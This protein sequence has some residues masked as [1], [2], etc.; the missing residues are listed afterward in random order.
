MGNHTDSQKSC[1]ATVQVCFCYIA[2]EGCS[3]NSELP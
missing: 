1:V 3:K 2:A